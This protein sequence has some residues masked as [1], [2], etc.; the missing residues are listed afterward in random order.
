MFIT[1]DMES[2]VTIKYIG[3]KKNI[4]IGTGTSLPDYNIVVLFFSAKIY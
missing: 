4:Y 3:T 1:N 2:I